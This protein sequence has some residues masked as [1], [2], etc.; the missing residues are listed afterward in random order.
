MFQWKGQLSICQR[1][2]GDATNPYGSFRCT[3]LK[4]TCK[5]PVF[6]LN[7]RARNEMNQ[8]YPLLVLLTRCLPLWT[9]DPAFCLQSLVLRGVLIWPRCC[10]KDSSWKC[11]HLVFN[12]QDL[13]EEAKGE[14]NMHTGPNQ[15]CQCWTTAGCTIISGHIHTYRT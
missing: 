15:A 10:P 13:H 11:R 7:D 1:P 4:F 6:N 12:C 3:M 9:P 14:D 8:G 5:V 2:M